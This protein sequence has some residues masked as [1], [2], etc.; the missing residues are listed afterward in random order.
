MLFIVSVSM[1]AYSMLLPALLFEHH[2][3][4]A[5]SHVLAWGWW[6]VLLLE[7]AWLANPIY[8]AAVLTFNSKYII[9]SQRATIA[10]L[11]LGLTSFHAKE[12]WFNEGSGTN[13]AGLGTGY[14]VW[15]ASFCVLLAGCFITTDAGDKA[16]HA[17]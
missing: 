17:A 3:P 14:Y 8:I 11:V 15:I 12:W 16:A 4:L 7:F 13:I 5:G 2:E 1:Y 10:S 9:F 6:G